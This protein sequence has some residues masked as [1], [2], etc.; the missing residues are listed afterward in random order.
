[1]GMREPMVPDPYD[2]PAE[3]GTSEQ[4]SGK[5]SGWWIAFSYA[6]P[7][8]VMIP[9]MNAAGWYGTGR[10]GSLQRLMQVG[11]YFSGIAAA[12]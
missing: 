10:S 11:A 12:G 2:S 4:R 7:L 6:L 3:K 1:M 5:L 8:L 9:F